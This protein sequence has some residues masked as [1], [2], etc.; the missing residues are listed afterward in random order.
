M[1]RRLTAVCLLV[2]VAGPAWADA[3]IERYSKSDGFAGMGGFESTTLETFSPEA[4]REETHLKFSSGFLAA[5]QKMAGFGDNVRITRLDR[6]LVWTLDPE[7]RT[8]TEAPLTA[9][10]ERQ[11]SLPGQRPP[12]SDG[13]PSDVVVTRNELKVE[14]TGAQKAINGFPCDEYL[15]TWVIETRNQKTGDTGKS[16]MTHRLW[17]TAETPEIRAV[18]AEEQAYTRAYLK[19]LGLD[20]SP[21]EAQKFAAGLAGLGEEDRRQAMA[22]LAAELGKVQGYP[23]ASQ[24]DWSVEGSAATASRPP[25]SAPAPASGSPP[26]PQPAPGGAGGQQQSL[27][28]LL[29]KILGAQAAKPGGQPQATGQPPTA[30]ATAGQE[31]RGPMYTLYTEVKSL[32]TVPAEGDR[33]EVPAGF[34]RK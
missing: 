29:S 27:N 32:R 1:A 8:Y 7:K 34:V 31:R 33:Y 20:L 4:H 17:T 21:G 3:V 11:R 16:L 30:P 9:K 13:E 2:L 15:M 12:R 23:I 24:L 6:D 19:K 5:L 18:Q 26:A 14:K 25:A 10:G 28:E 22:R